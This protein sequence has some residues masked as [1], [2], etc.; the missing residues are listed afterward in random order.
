[1]F[2]IHNI[3]YNRLHENASVYNKILELKTIIYARIYVM[4]KN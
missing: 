1:M 4:I 2:D 3:L